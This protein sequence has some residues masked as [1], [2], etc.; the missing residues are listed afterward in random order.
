MLRHLVLTA[1]LLGAACSPPAGDGAQNTTTDQAEPAAP[2]AQHAPITAAGTVTAVDASAGTI[3]INHTAIAAINWP[4]MEMQFTAEDPAILQDL[5]VGDR[6]QFE[7][8][9]AAES[10]VVTAVRKD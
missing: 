5:A 2:A 7:L 9:S 6:V 1:A 4:A 10:T 8:K 3:S